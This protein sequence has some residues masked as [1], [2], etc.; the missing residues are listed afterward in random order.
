M[1]IIINYFL[2]DFLS[3]SLF[4]GYFAEAGGEVYWNISSYFS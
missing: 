2:P 1:E 3:G 4:G